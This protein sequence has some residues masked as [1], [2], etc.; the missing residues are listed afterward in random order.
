DGA[1]APVYE[2]I[3]RH[4]SFEKLMRGLDTLRRKKERYQS[5][6]PHLQYELVVQR[7]NVH[8]L[9]EFVDLVDGLGGRTVTFEHVC[10]MPHLEIDYARWLPTFE[11]AQGRARELGIQLVGSGVEKFR[12]AQAAD[13]PAADPPPSGEV[14]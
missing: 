4:G 2:S 12:A 1:S 7:D 13:R 3:R 9:P 14:I 10:G 11:R 6:V 8:E 5:V